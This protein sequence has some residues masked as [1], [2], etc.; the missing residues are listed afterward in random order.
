MPSDTSAMTDASSKPPTRL[1]RKSTRKSK[2]EDIMKELEDYVNE[3][4]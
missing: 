2:D 4:K 1:S 3:K